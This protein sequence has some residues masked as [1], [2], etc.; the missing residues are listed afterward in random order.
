MNFKIFLV[1]KIDK[2][3]NIQVEQGEFCSIDINLWFKSNNLTPTLMNEVR[4]Y[5]F[6]EWLNKKINSYKN[7]IILG[8]PLFIA[9]ENI[10][11]LFIDFLKEKISNIFP[12][13]FYDIILSDE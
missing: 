7:R 9:Y 10:T 11:P 8:Q 3:K 4:Q 1:S 6:E 2:I 12:E 5:I 13:H